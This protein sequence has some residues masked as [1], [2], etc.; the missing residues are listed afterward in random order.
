MNC[1]LTLTSYP[2]WGFRH[3]TNICL[4]NAQRTNSTISSD[5]L[6]QAGGVIYTVQSDSTLEEGGAVAVC[7]DSH[8]SCIPSSPPPYENK[9]IKGVD[10]E[11][12]QL[13]VKCAAKRNAISQSTK[14]HTTMNVVESI[15]SFL[16]WFV[17]LERQTVH[18]L[19]RF[20]TLQQSNS[21]MT[22]NQ[23]HAKC[24]IV[25]RN[26]LS[27][28]MWAI[29]I[30][31]WSHWVTFFH[32][33]QR[34]MHFYQNRQPHKL[35]VLNFSSQSWL[36]FVACLKPLETRSTR[37]PKTSDQG[38]PGIHTHCH[39]P[40]ST[41]QTSV[42]LFFHAETNVLVHSSLRL[43]MERAGQKCGRLCGSSSARLDVGKTGQF[44]LVCT[45]FAQSTT[46]P[47]NDTISGSMNTYVD[48]LLQPR[49][50][51]CHL[52]RFAGLICVPHL[53]W[54]VS[55]PCWS[56]LSGNWDV[57]SQLRLPSSELHKNIYLHASTEWRNI[58]VDVR[59][60]QR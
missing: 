16:W 59:Q 56:V 20:R 47:A 49:Q 3:G 33:K 23:R 36:G 14:S 43:A 34:P 25:W 39:G 45:S 30:K 8:P 10:V 15:L 19:A 31:L 37:F 9:K 57:F 11:Q 60:L 52:T 38:D 51:A 5:N 44:Q 54:H 4:R 7:T 58:Q 24:V 32:Q 18:S 55:P 22:R 53:N 29:G 40:V 12:S 48:T 17:I 1:L 2:P 26:V 41:N 50:F 13:W 46:H 21:A 42:W 28:V 27:R 6:G 35:S